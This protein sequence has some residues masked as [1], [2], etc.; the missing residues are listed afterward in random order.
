MN[1]FKEQFY[2]TYRERN[3]P[4][5]ALM[6]RAPVYNPVPAPATNINLPVFQPM[7]RQQ[8]RTQAPTMQDRI[9]SFY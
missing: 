1:A 3:R 4:T 8:L 6:P 5:P 2:K 7:Q 9:G